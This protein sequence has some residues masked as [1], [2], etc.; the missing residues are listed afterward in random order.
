MPRKTPVE[1][2]GLDDL[3]C[4]NEAAA[5]CRGKRTPH[6]PIRIAV[7]ASMRPRPDAAENARA[8]ARA[9]RCA[10]CFNEAAARCRG[11]PVRVDDPGLLPLGF[12]EAAARCRGKLVCTRPGPG[13]AAVAS[14]RPRPDAAENA[15]ARRGLD[16]GT[17]SFNEAAARCRGKQTPRP[18]R[19]PT[20]SWL[21]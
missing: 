18:S 8:P 9:A 17:R 7:G 12:N 5:R 19:W 1:S 6:G 4:F 10:A 3:H 20:A 2:D 11:K 14:M 13:T 15:R 16:R 21:Q